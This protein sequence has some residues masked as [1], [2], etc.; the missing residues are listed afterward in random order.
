M[1]PVA[2]KAQISGLG[3]DD[4]RLR[5]SWLS[6]LSTEVKASISACLIH[7]HQI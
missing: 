3:H 2:K 7:D 4:P 5:W 6:G 1:N